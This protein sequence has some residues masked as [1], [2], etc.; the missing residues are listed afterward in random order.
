MK[1]LYILIFFSVSLLSW[2]VNAQRITV[3]GN[4]FL[5]E[6]KEIFMNGANTPWNNWND[7]GG[8]YKS[9]WWDAEFKRIKNSG[10]IPPGYGLPAVDRWA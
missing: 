8:N 1:G 7:F 6:G 3:S 4:K 9:A 2:N 5:V 10:V